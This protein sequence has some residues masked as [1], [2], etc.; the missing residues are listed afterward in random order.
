MGN[1]DWWTRSM[2]RVVLGF[3]FLSVW[4]CPAYA[5]RAER[6]ERI[7][8]DTVYTNTDFSFALPL[9][10][11]WHRHESIRFNHPHK[12]TSI[13]RS[14]LELFEKKFNYL[15]RIHDKALVPA[16]ICILAKPLPE[17]SRGKATVDVT[18]YQSS[19]AQMKQDVQAGPVRA[20]LGGL[21][22]SRI[23]LR[24][25]V[26]GRQFYTRVYSLRVLDHILDF[27][28]TARSSAKLEEMD[29]AIR[30][31]RFESVTSSKTDAG[32]GK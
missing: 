19:W 32:E 15:Q 22:A 2:L 10:G 1:G 5:R 17:P 28:L 30:K 13:A 31:V 29:L 11:G 21:N 3:I 7:A 18:E 4:C 20:Q 6:W 8:A 25:E 23:D 12:Q 24:A 9:P 27:I 14:V 16:S 26:E